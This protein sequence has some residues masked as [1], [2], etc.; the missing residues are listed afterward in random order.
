MSTNAAAAT[1]LPNVVAPDA[2]DIMGFMS[3]NYETNFWSCFADPITCCSVMCCA[4]IMIGIT[5]GKIHKNGAFDI[6][7]CCCSGY[8]SYRIRRRVQ[9]MFGIKESEDASVCAVAC[10]NLCTVTQDIR[11]LNA[12]GGAAA[13]A[14][15]ANEPQPQMEKS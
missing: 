7:A 6:P 1:Q 10:C 5:S 8:G 12:R 9:A 14:V 11:E 4:P 3:S 15:A 2:N 13:V